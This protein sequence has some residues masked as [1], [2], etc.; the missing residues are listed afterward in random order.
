MQAFG[1]T[2]LLKKRDSNTGAYL[3]ILRKFLKN[4]YFKENLWTAAPG[5]CRANF[6][7]CLFEQG[8]LINVSQHLEENTCPRLSFLILF[9][10]WGWGRGGRGEGEWIPPPPL[11]CKLF[12]TTSIWM[13]RSIWFSVTL[14]FIELQFFLLNLG[15]LALANLKLERFCLKSFRNILFCDP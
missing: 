15:V 10:I 4:I 6:F 3:W 13:T 9:V 5:K 8:V 7:I 2:T 14:S 1:S 11:P 12:F